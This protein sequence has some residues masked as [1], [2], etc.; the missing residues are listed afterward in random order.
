[1][2]TNVEGTRPIV[3]RIP[4]FHFLSNSVAKARSLGSAATRAMYSLLM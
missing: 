3:G 4:H 1:M 2:V